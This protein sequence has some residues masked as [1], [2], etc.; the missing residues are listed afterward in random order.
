MR[1]SRQSKVSLPLQEEEQGSRHFRLRLIADVRQARVL[2]LDRSK[3]LEE[4]ENDR[5]G[6]PNYDSHVVTECHRLRTIPLRDFTVENLRLMIGQSIGLD[7]LVP[8]AIEV[9]VENPLVSGDCY[10]GDL[11]KQ[12]LSI[13]HEYWKSHPTLHS[14]I[15][16]IVDDVDGIVKTVQLDT[17][18]LADSVRGL[19][20]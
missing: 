20:N 14:E 11:L 17:R 6:P 1:W 3:S 19:S 10:P 5:W 16:G 12:V 13:E 4:L 7:Y 2:D 8:L 18:P 9:L 15:C